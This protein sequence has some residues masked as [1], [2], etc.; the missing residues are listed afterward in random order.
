MQKADHSTFAQKKSIFNLT[1]ARF[2]LQF[3]HKLTSIKVNFYAV[4]IAHVTALLLLILTVLGA[5]MAGDDA[6]GIEYKCT[7]VVG[8]G[9]AESAD[10]HRLLVGV[11]FA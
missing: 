2:A 10:C 6:A 1:I 4:I 5:C 9:Q 8:Q 7:A 3:S 11:K